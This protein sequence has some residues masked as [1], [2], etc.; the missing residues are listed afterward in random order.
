MLHPDL[1]VTLCPHRAKKLHPSRASHLALQHCRGGCPVPRAASLSQR[2]FVPHTLTCVQTCMITH[3]SFWLFIHLQTA[4]PQ[5]LAIVVRS[6][7]VAECLLQRQD[8]HP[9]D[10]W[11]RSRAHVIGLCKPSTALNSVY[12]MRAMYSY[13]YMA[14]VIILWFQYLPCKLF[15][16]F[17]IAAFWFAFTIVKYLSGKVFGA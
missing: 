5:H 9:W 4:K 12:D 13:L 14:V 10:P 2:R 1:M 11:S 8:F 16:G 7:I 17:N 15:A 3:A 6:R